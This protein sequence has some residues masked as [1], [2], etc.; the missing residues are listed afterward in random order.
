MYEQTFCSDLWLEVDEQNHFEKKMVVEIKFYL[1][2]I[3]EDT[4]N[5]YRVSPVVIILYSLLYVKCYTQKLWYFCWSQNQ[6]IRS[7]ASDMWSFSFQTLLA[8]FQVFIETAIARKYLAESVWCRKSEN[9]KHYFVINVS[10]CNK[11]NNLGIW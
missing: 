2:Q 4:K 10:V 11:S 9:W 5:C 7:I 1:V 3:V 8:H 6:F